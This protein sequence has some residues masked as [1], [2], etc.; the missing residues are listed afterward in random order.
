MRIKNVYEILEI[1]K[2]K[3][4]NINHNV[5]RVLKYIYQ[6]VYVKCFDDVMAKHVDQVVVDGAQYG[7][8][9]YNETVRPY[10]DAKKNM[11]VYLDGDESIVVYLLEMIKDG[12]EEFI[13]CF[14]D[15]V[16]TYFDIVDDRFYTNEDFKI[17]SFSFNI[18]CMLKAYH[19]HKDNF[20]L[21][22]KIM[23][24]S[25]IL[26][27]CGG[28]E[29]KYL[30]VFSRL[31]ERKT[32]LDSFLE[33]NSYDKANM[34]SS[35]FIDVLTNIGKSYLSYDVDNL[36]ADLKMFDEV[37]SDYDLVSSVVSKDK[38]ISFDEVVEKCVF[39]KYRHRVYPFYSAN[40]LVGDRLEFVNK[41]L[42]VLF[43]KENYCQA[44]FDKISL[45]DFRL[46]NYLNDLEGEKNDSFVQCLSVLFDSESFF[47]FNSKVNIL[48]NASILFKDGNISESLE[49]VKSIESLKH[50]KSIDGNVLTTNLINKP[51]N[52]ETSIFRRMV[53]LYNEYYS[54]KDFDVTSIMRRVFDSS[55]LDKIDA[56]IDKGI[57]EELD[58]IETLRKIEERRQ[59]EIREELEDMRE[60]LVHSPSASV[61]V[62]ESPPAVAVKKPRGFFGRR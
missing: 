22:S 52:S 33:C 53:N 6:D 37:V 61:N 50:K 24:D 21:F 38:L 16:K 62:V 57:K 55:S 9:R 7:S 47:E 40:L 34:I 58:S 10:L 39:R 48:I 30:N 44:A 35:L 56:E 11:S 51:D 25:S 27:N 5:H 13:S 8:I 15:K 36:K 14:F 60:N 20:E 59:T 19:E 32:V 17:Y 12:K 1:L 43:E 31:C 18:Y 3:D 4:E 54:D 2:N 28:F 46:F 23:D 49:E 26:I 29:D 41:R 42:K 45:I